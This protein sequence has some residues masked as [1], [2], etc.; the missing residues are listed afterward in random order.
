M[1]HYRTID[2]PIET[3]CS[4]QLIFSHMQDSGIQGMTIRAGWRS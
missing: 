3:L 4:W 1:T 2:S